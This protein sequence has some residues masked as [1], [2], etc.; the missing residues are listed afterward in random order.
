MEF[1]LKPSK[2]HRIAN[3]RHKKYSEQ[4]YKLI[5]NQDKSSNHSYNGKFNFK[6]TTATKYKYSYDGYS[7]ACGKCRQM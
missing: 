6:K 7:G 1:D 3:M 4:K 2:C 5:D